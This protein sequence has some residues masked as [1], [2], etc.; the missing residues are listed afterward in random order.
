MFDFL[1]Q[2]RCSWQR[3]MTAILFPFFRSI[4]GRQQS[5]ST[6]TPSD[7]KTQHNAELEVELLISSCDLIAELTNGQH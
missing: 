6:L 3:K 2:I 5:K 1:L 4:E 7:S